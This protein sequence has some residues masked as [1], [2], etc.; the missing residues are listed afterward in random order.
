[1]KY[2]SNEY[3]ILNYLLSRNTISYE[4][5]IDW[6]YSQY[7][8]EGI[9]P[10]IEKITLATDLGEIYQLISDAYQVSGEPE[11][12]FLIGEIVSKYHNDEITINE[13]IG[14]ILYDLDANLSKEDNQKMYLADDLFGWHDLPEK[15]AIK[16]VSEIFDRYRPIYE[17]AVSKFKA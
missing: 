16:L 5:V 2:R 14:R 13:A 7:T 4:G 3:N 11:E 12:S 9:D 1:M 8:N 17:S 15:E 6:A 10:F